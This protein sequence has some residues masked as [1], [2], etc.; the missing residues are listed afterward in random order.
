MKRQISVLG[1]LFSRLAKD[2]QGGETPEY[3][4]TLGF[5]AVGCFVMI[6][7]VGTKFYSLWDRIDRALAMIG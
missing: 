1:K 6:Q 2:E 4:L 3:A 5:I 7:M